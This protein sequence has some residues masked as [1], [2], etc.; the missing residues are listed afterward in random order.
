MK[1]RWLIGALLVTM[2]GNLTIK[3]LAN[4]VFAGAN[5]KQAPKQTYL[6]ENNDVL[7]YYKNSSAG[8]VSGLVGS[9]LL[10]QLAKI[11]TVKHRYYTSYGDCRGAMAFADEDPNDSS[12]IITFYAQASVDNTWNDGA[13]YNREHVWCKS[14]SGGLYP[15]VSNSESNAG[16]DIHQLKPTIVSINTQ[17]SNNKYGNLNKQGT[18]LTYKNEGIGCY[19]NTAK[20]VFEPNDKIKG[21]VARILMY[22]Y[23][24]YSNEVTNATSKY[25]GNLK[26][27]NIVSAP[28]GST[29]AAWDLLLDW[30]ELDPVDEFEINRNNYCASITGVR[31]PYI[32][33][34]EFANMIW[35][36]DY[37]GAGALE[38]SATFKVNY[39]ASLGFATNDNY[40]IFD[41]Y[42]IIIKGEPT[43]AENYKYGYIYTNYANFQEHEYTSF[44]DALASNENDFTKVVSTLKATS[45]ENTKEFTIDVTNKLE[46][47]AFAFYFIDLETNKCYFSNTK[48]ITYD[49][50][51]KIYIQNPS[52]LDSLSNKD[53]ILVALLTIKNTK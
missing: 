47:Y 44:T 34:P 1:K 32:D 21:D 9:E 39:Q 17:R 46:Q 24:H 15:S 36:K 5:E 29:Q 35:Q 19:L 48:T 37:N 11:S 40:T 25:K 18:E 42:K 16:T 26:I 45:E 7:G 20:D 51:I 12:K 3:T 22:M 23:T 49:D 2:L 53:D 52:Y 38:D 6:A 28:S 30:H 10:E 4:N 27:T 50:L 14:L 43:N 31:N 33:F 41:N 13:V 8:S